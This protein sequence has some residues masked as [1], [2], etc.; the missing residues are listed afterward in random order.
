MRLLAIGGVDDHIHL[1]LSLAKTM[2]IAKAMQLI[3]GGSSKWV[4]DEF[5]DHRLF[6]WQEGYGAFS[7]GIGE[8]ERTVRYIDNQVE[9]HKKKDFKTEFV[10]FLDAHFVEYELKHVFD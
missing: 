2:D 1:L 6:E 7:I 9:H 4:H 3:K 8:V 10:S 5:P